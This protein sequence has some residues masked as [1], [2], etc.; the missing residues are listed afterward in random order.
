M[1]ADSSGRA[2]RTREHPCIR[3]RWGGHRHCSKQ[4]KSAKSAGRRTAE[5][6][7]SFPLHGLQMLPTTLVIALLAL[8]ARA[9]PTGTRRRGVPQTVTLRSRTVD[10]SDAHFRRALSPIDVPLAD[11]FNGTDLQ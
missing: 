3:P 11:Y 1:P 5:A 9:T 4:Y 7:S 6:S 10:R 8:A 2:S